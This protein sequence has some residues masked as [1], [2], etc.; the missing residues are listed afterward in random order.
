MSSHN[1][2]LIHISRRRNLIVARPFGESSV[3][4]VARP[5]IRTDA[6]WNVYWNVTREVKRRFDA[7]GISIPFPQQD[8]HVYDTGATPP[9]LPEKASPNPA[10]SDCLGTVPSA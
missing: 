2:G 4:F 5:W 7:E 1:P 9:I 6:Y 3:D 10:R 8:V